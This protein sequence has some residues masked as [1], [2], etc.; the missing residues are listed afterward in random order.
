MAREVLSL[1][2]V[3]DK[4]DK[5]VVAIEGEELQHANEEPVRI[6][7]FEKAEE[8]KEPVTIAGFE[9]IDNEVPKDTPES[10]K[11]KRSNY[12][13]WNIVRA[14][15]GAV[16]KCLRGEF[17]NETKAAQAVASYLVTL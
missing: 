13:M 6:A 11:L 16:P 17:T 8:S 15:G 3:V 5:D 12:A 2:K 9:H 10:F 4:D 1:N 7:G 14:G